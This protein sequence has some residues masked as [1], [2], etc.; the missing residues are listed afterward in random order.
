MAIHNYTIEQLKFIAEN[1]GKLF[2]VLIYDKNNRLILTNEIP[3]KIKFVDKSLTKKLY[4]MYES[5]EGYVVSTM[6]D[7]EDYLG[8]VEG[9]LYL[10]SPD[11]LI[12]LD[13]YYS[14]FDRVLIKNSNDDDCYF[15]LMEIY[16]RNSRVEPDIGGILRSSYL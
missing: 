16:L 9:D 14:T 7:D 15:Y 6:T 8:N 11:M 1:K 13:N 2:P 5:L 4:V 3:E 12:D 10:V